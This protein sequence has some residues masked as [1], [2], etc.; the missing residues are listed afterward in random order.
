AK[1]FDEA[2]IRMAAAPAPGDSSAASPCSRLWN[3]TCSRQS[4]SR[5]DI[6][7]RRSVLRAGVAG[8]VAALLPRF[9]IGQSADAR[10]LRFVQQAWPAGRCAIRSVR[11]LRKRWMNGAWRT[12]RL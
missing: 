3:P 2:A 6:M 11:R 4:I 10:V 9:A 1:L 5:G 12:T 8:G 7:Q